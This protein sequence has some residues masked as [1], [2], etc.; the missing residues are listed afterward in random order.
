[1][2][3]CILLFHTMDTFTGNN[4]QKWRIHFM[5]FG[6]K[7]SI[8]VAESQSDCSIAAVENQSMGVRK[9]EVTPS[10]EFKKMTSYAAF[11]R[12]TLKVL[13]APTPLSMHMLTI[14]LKKSQTKTQKCLICVFGAPKIY[15]HFRCWEFCPLLEKF[16]WAP[17]HELVIN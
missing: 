1:M 15:R 12:N 10:L 7:F 4:V 3:W 14:N 6:F 13:L 11:L 17:T 5:K 2:S 8:T 16:L 9:G